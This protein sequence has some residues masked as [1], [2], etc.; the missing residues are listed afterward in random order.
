MDALTNGHSPVDLLADSRPLPP[1]RSQSSSP[2]KYQVSRDGNQVESEDRMQN[3]A[4]QAAD[5]LHNHVPKYVDY[6]FAQRHLAALPGEFISEVA[7]IR[8]KPTSLWL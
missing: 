1:R 8:K 4:C 3:S 2:L 6:T 5:N 7:D